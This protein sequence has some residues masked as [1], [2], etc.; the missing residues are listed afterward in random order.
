MIY[1]SY[2]NKHRH[3]N[4][5]KSDKLHFGFIERRDPIKAVYFTNMV[6]YL[7]LAL[8]MSMLAGPIVLG[9]TM[10]I[11]EAIRSGLRAELGKYENS[12]F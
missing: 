7:F 5:L 8:I 10:V 1:N 11:R 12:N 2:E 6:I 9:N 4:G 3:S